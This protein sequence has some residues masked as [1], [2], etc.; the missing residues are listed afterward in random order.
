MPGGA[1][2]G[3]VRVGRPREQ[4]PGPFGQHDQTQTT[5][6]APRLGVAGQDV[7]GGG[8]RGPAEGGLGVDGEGDAR[9]AGRLPGRDPVAQGGIG[10]DGLVEG[11]SETVGVDPEELPLTV[12]DRS[13]RGSGQQGSGVLDRAGHPTPA[14]AT[15]RAPDARDVAHGDAQPIPGRVADGHHRRADR[16]CGPVAPRDRRRVAGVDPDH[17]QVAVAIGAEDLALGLAAIGEEHMHL[18]AVEV[19]CVG[20]DLAGLDHD[21]GP[22]APSVA[23]ANRRSARRGCDRCDR[24][25]ELIHGT[26]RFILHL[27]ACDLQ[28]ASYSIDSHCQARCPTIAPCLLPRRHWPPRSNASIAYWLYA[29]TNTI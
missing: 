16:Q 17:R 13:T 7:V 19:V 20:E 26:H 2:E 28:C 25:A 6:A 9:R 1:V 29:V 23:N 8:R 22:A 27:V 18:V 3:G 12:D 24:L 21:A 14:R 11:A 15:E 5:G 10:R 4:P